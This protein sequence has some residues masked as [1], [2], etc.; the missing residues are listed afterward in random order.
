LHDHFDA[1]TQLHLTD[2]RVIRTS[3]NT[4]TG[5]II[6]EHAL[7]LASE[8]SR[9]S[10]DFFLCEHR[11]YSAIPFGQRPSKELR[12]VR[13]DIDHQSRSVGCARRLPRQEHACCQSGASLLEL[14]SVSA[15]IVLMAGLL[16]SSAASFSSSAGR[17]GA[18]NVLMN[19][20]EHARITA[21]ESGQT[22]HLGFA[23]SDFPIEEM[24]YKAFLIFRDTSEEER[25][26]GAKDYLILRKWTKLPRNVA[27]KRMTGSV[28]PESGGHAFPGLNGVLPNHQHDEVFP[29]LSFN[30]SGAVSG[31]SDPIELFL[32]EG[33]YSAGQDIQTRNSSGLFEKISLSRYTGR[34]QFN[35]TRTDVQ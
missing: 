30:S 2:L 22:V 32:Y 34:A 7:A 21:L 14:L 16:Y 33:Y 13:R 24:R 8:V 9:Q 19:A 6:I 11:S 29:C 25:T 5:H 20:L 15:L 35:V 31:S 23:D 3:N 18:V 4:H 10:R 27:V 12:S 1:R 26:A 28:V 17:R